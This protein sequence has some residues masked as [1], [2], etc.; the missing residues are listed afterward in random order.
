MLEANT[1]KDKPI[2]V[3]GATGNLW[4]NSF[5]NAAYQCVLLYVP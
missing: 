2:L 4:R 5:L 3:T 1:T